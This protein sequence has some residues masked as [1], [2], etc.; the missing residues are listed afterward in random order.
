MQRALQEL[1]REELIATDRTRG[2]YVTD[3]RKSIDMLA[4]DA[5]FDAC[6]ALITVADDL[7]MT[8][9]GHHITGKTLGKGNKMK[10]TEI[11]ISPWITKTLSPVDSTDPG[12]GRIVGLLG[13]NGAGKTTLLKILAGLEMNYKGD[14][15]VFGNRPG[16]LTKST[17]AT[18][19]I[20]CLPELDGGRCHRPLRSHTRRFRRGKA[21]EM[22]ERF[23]L[24][25]IAAFGN[26]QGYAG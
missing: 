2:K 8:K 26:E 19:P 20:T 3:N 10:A 23:K 7:S 14:V 12:R 13:P 16:P 25:G 21:R 9:D 17:S 5:F 22:L 15:K 1:E 18:S 6:D 4:K 11:K 24:G